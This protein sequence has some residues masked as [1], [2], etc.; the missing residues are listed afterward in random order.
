M[1]EGG[2]LENP[3]VD[4]TLGLHIW[5]EKPVGWLGICNGPAMAGAE[6]FKIKVEGKGGHAAAPHL[7]IDPVLAAAQII[8]ALQGIVARNVAPLQTAV[9]SVCTIHGGETFNVMPSAVELTGTIRTFELEIRTR[10]LQR[11]EET[12]RGV[13][14]AM[15]CQARIDLQRLTPATVN[16][17]GIA[18]IVQAAARCLFP[19]ADID[20]SN[21][22]TMGSEDFAFLLEKVPGCFFFIGSA[23]PEKGLDAGHHHPKF[24]FNEVVLPR[25]AALMAVSVVN[26]LQ[27]K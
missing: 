4:G 24:D 1:I 13:A 2:A 16:Q 27:N 7:T 5:N 25:A 17:P 19:D 21:Y 26:L 15:G 23:N 10:V 12:V 6:I 22:V 20:S 11:F 9:V 14:E 18:R 3:K 8:S